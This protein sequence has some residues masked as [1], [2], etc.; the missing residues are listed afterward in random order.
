VRHMV[1]YEDSLAWYLEWEHS[2]GYSC[3]WFRPLT[4]PRLKKLLRSYPNQPVC[5]PR[6][7]TK[8]ACAT[9][10]T[11]LPVS[12]KKSPEKLLRRQL[13]LMNSRLNKR[14][15]CVLSSCSGQPIG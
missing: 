12:G 11:S 3:G 14:M 1:K 5:G 7:K 4:L 13:L 8:S 10:Q 15:L 6:L 2:V 9:E